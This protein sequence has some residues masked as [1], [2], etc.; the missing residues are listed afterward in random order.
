MACGEVLRQGEVDIE[1]K[2]FDE[3]HVSDDHERRLHQMLERWYFSC[4]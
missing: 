3:I 2:T 1:F 4:S